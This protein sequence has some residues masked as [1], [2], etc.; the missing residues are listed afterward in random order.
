MQCALA[1]TR[2]RTMLALTK[3]AGLGTRQDQREGSSQVRTCKGADWWFDKV[4]QRRITVIKKGLGPEFDFPRRSWEAA[5]V[6]LVVDR[7]VLD[8]SRRQRFPYSGG[9]RSKLL[10]RNAARTELLPV[11]GID[12]TVPEMLAE[13]E[14][15]SKA[16]DEIG[17]GP[18]L[19]GRGND[20]L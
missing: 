5:R 2:K 20:R 15:R 18:G 19:V 4:R 6:S 16:E 10:Q 17:V 13:A 9:L 7:G 14:T 1:Q 11:S 12:I 3:Q 8:V